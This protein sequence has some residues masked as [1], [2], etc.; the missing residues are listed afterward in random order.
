M[1]N[2]RFRSQKFD[3]RMVGKTIVVGLLAL[4]VAPCAP[5]QQPG[6]K[7][8]SSALDAT[9]ALVSALQAD[10]E[11]ALLKILGPDAKDIISSGDRTEDRTNHE[12]FVEKYKKMHR[13]VDEPDG[14]TTLYIGAENW[15][16]PIPLK[17]KGASW[18]F[19]TA[20]GKKEI[21]YRRIGRNELSAIQVCHELV[22][23]EKEYYGQPHDGESAN[24]YA[25]KLIS[26][27]G[28]QDGLYWQASAGE[29]ESPIGPMLAAAAEASDKKPEPFEGYYY[30]ILTEQKDPGGVRSYIVDG[31]MT[32]GFAVLAY[33]AE[34]RVSGVMTF[35]VNQGGVV[36][37]KDLGPHT[38]DIA[39][40]LTRYDRDA[41]WRQ[42]D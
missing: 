34:Y 20:A 18:Y 5:A 26:D 31:K 24:Q 3:F 35:L 22:D 25:Q 10:D 36:Y 42:A 23:A 37:E 9:E 2:V 13:L 39:K 8:F 4:A 11:S 17:H 38:V 21:L 32:R 27:N 1:F 29:A 19:D 40:R 41:S 33:P 7:T 16:T 14:T 15:P 30:R 28:K 12:Q 6:Q